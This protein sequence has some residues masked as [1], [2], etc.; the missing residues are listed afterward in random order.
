MR[1]KPS[2]TD[3]MVLDGKV[4]TPRDT[5]EICFTNEGLDTN[6]PLREEVITNREAKES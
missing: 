1:R 5:D 3:Q 6:R 4:G 2:E